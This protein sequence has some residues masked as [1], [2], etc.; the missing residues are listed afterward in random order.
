[1]SKPNNS[2]K[3]RTTYIEPTSEVKPPQSTYVQ[4]NAGSIIKKIN[5]KK[6]K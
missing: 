3:P 5:Q 6:G 1:M 4:N 2:E